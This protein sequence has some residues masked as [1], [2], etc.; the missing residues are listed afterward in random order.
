MIILE[1]EQRTEEW[2]MARA[3]VPSASNFDKIVTSKGV[4]TSGVTR[5]K[6]IYKLA[7]EIITGKHEESYTNAAMQHGIDTEEEARNMY[8]LVKG[9]EV[10]EVG[11]CMLD[12][13]SSGASPD[14]MVGED[15]LLE[16]KC[17]KVET[18]IDYLLN[19]KI[20]TTY[21]PQVQGQL[22]VTGRKW[23][24]FMSYSDGLKP[25]IVRVERDEVFIKKLET[26][27]ANFSKELVSIVDQI[28][29]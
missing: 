28:K 10:N 9:I 2:F 29:G 24:D 20:P 21:I 22:F 18:H 17:P 6:Y 16:I 12:D 4:A 8:E 3:G 27:L 11:F 26:E 19:N 13:K 15:G 23:C 14:G 1:M 25:L 7:A 5:K